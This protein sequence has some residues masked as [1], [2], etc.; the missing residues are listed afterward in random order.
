MTEVE[1]GAWISVYVGI[2]LIGACLR[3]SERDSTE[4]DLFAGLR[5][6]GYGLLLIGLLI[7][8]VELLHHYY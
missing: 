8:G 6:P 4:S 2:G 3:S 1:L 5:F 7:L